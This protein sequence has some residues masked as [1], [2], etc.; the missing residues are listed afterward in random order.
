VVGV[1]LLL[2]RLLALPMR[3][4]LVSWLHRAEVRGNDIDA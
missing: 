2:L 3:T 1:V 4:Q